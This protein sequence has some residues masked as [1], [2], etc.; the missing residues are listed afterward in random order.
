M[1]TRRFAVENVCT[2]RLNS[3]IYPV[4]GIRASRPC[5]I[6][7]RRRSRETKLQ[8]E[9]PICPKGS[10]R[11]P[12]FGQPVVHRSVPHI[13]VFPAQ[14]TT[15]AATDAYGSTRSRY[16]ARHSLLVHYYYYYNVCVLVMY[17]CCRYSSVVATINPLDTFPV[18]PLES[19]LRFPSPPVA[20]PFP[21]IP[22]TLP[23]P[24][25]VRPLY[26]SNAV[27]F[28]SLRG[29]AVRPDRPT[30]RILTHRSSAPIRTGPRTVEKRLKQCARSFRRKRFVNI[31]REGRDDTLRLP[32]CAKN[33]EG[34]HRMRVAG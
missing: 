12:V 7:R 20:V 6:R 34:S 30:G 31:A 21:S 17:S 18:I 9:K 2:H 19:P 13:A 23:P 16:V 29:A 10:P 14:K 15:A 5:D 24:P 3:G 4:R 22:Q 33:Q 25:I 26:A 1:K 27:V 32:E 11:I 8:R 28:S